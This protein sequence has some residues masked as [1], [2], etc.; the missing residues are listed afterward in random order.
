MRVEH[1]P[2]RSGD[3]A[4]LDPHHA[5]SLVAIGPVASGK[6]RSKNAFG[7]REPGFEVVLVAEDFVGP[8]EAQRSLP[9]LS[10]VPVGVGRGNLLR[11]RV[12]PRSDRLF[13]TLGI[14]QVGMHHAVCNSDSAQ[15]FRQFHLLGRTFLVAELRVVHGL[16]AEQFHPLLPGQA[17][18]AQSLVG[19]V[20]VLPRRLVDD[21]RL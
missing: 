12:E 6:L 5:V 11:L 16:A 17:L 4:V 19:K 7:T 2:E 9:Q 14:V 8:E 15:Q 21:Q 13:D 18:V 1:D 20:L 3:K 10:G